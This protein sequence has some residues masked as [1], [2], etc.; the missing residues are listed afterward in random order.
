MGLLLHTGSGRLVV[1]SARTLIGRSPV[2]QVRVEDPR[3]SGEHASIAWVGEGWEVHDLGSR[4]GTML[5]GARLGTGERAPLG[6]DARLGFGSS[7]E[8]WVLAD[9]SA[10]GPAARNERTEELVRS[11][12]ALLALPTADD[13]QATVFGRADGTWF[14]EVGAVVRPVAD[15]E[16]I[17]LG[18]ASWI[19]FLPRDL[20]A[21]PATAGGDGS[22]RALRE[23]ELCFA[24][25]RDEEH[26]ELRV[27][28]GD[29]QQGVSLPA[30][31]SHYMLL[32]LARA[33]LRDARA[34]L[35]LDEQGWLYSSELADMLRYTP[36]RLNVEIF[37][38]RNQFAKL[39]FAESEQ[40]IERRAATRQIRIGVARLQVTRP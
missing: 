39:G 22:T 20:G 16:R 33:R 9:A 25:S 31:S 32:L 27:R 7:V 17:E 36:E 18:G 26:V 40:L 19:L 24:P 35:P 8:T 2:C 34:D 1:L 13:P 11:A 28:Q 15:R 14:V 4:N 30:R 6:R 12:S 29:A 37:R 10:P 23:L 3:A 21:I 5:D 38:A